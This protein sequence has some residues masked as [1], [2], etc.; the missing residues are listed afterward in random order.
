[1]RH[2]SKTKQYHLLHLDLA[3]LFVSSPSVNNS[4]LSLSL[5]HT[6]TH[7]PLHAPNHH[8]AS[9]LQSNEPENTHN[10]CFLARF[11]GD[12]SVMLPARLMAGE[13]AQGPAQT[14]T[15]LQSLTGSKSCTAAGPTLFSQHSA[16]VDVEMTFGVSRRLNRIKSLKHVTK[17]MSEGEGRGQDSD[18]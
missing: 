1:M 12:A 5:S 9:R 8:P 3:F 15:M 10:N 6:H 7:T 18:L 17:H 13:A 14:V 2:Q 4:S 11:R 16:T